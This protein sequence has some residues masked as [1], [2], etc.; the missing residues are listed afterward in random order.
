MTHFSSPTGGFIGQPL[1]RFGVGDLLKTPHGNG[2]VICTHA[3]NPTECPPNKILLRS[4][5]DLKFWADEQESSYIGRLDRF[6]KNPPV[7]F[8]EE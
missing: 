5:D 8:S 2:M 6:F 1:K 3:T 7:I 4:P